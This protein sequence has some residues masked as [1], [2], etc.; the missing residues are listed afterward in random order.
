[1]AVQR[2]LPVAAQRDS[3]WLSLMLIMALISMA[4]SAQAEEKNI[5]ALGYFQP[6]GG[7]I[8]ITG[9]PGV[10][11]GKILV[12]E[13]QAVK[14]GDM[15]VL[16]ENHPS[17]EEAVE[18]EQLGLDELDVQHEDD[19]VIKELNIADTK[20]KVERTQTN[21]KNYLAIGKNA[22]VPTVL[23]QRKN[24]V[25]DARHALNIAQTALH[26]AKHAYRATRKKLSAKLRAAQRELDENRITA[27]ID[28]VI[29]GIKK[30]VGQNSGGVMMTIANLG[31]MEVEC[32]IYEGD[33][34]R[35]KKGMKATISS[36]SL[37]ETLT[38]KVVSISRQIDSKRKV[39]KAR[40]QLDKSA[41]ANRMI[42]M[43]VNVKI[44]E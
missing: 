22:I 26:A 11:I 31:V 10:M 40:V 19:L 13:D 18:I 39:A 3:G 1:M 16:L 4:A 36:K 32:D 9:K 21:L 2:A 6:Q 8:T 35:L 17:K 14:R 38:G 25:T 43:E 37:Q 15:V 27:P 34:I 5:G 33:L 12:Q 24:D 23:S 28:G 29:I 42:G 7:I 30:L 44:S 41:P 20:T